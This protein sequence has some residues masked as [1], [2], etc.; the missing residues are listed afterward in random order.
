VVA[1]HLY[2]GSSVDFIADATQN[3]IASK[4][5]ATFFHA[6]RYHAPQS[7]VRSWQ[8]SLRAMAT[9]LQL[10][11][12]HDNG[13]IVEWQLPLSS[14]R[15]DIMV[16]G[17][18]ADRRAGAVIVELKQW[19]EVAE[20]AIEDCVA[21]FVGGRERDVLHPSRQVDNYQR[22]LEDTHTAF[23][24]GSIALRSCAY[25]H[26]LLYDP[27]HLLFDK[28]FGPVLR[29]CPT[30]ASDRLD[31]LVA[32]VAGG[33]G[34]GGG[35]RVM[36][37]VLEGR[38]RPH[39]RLLDH[40]AQVIRNEPTYVLLDEQQVAF[41]A[42]LTRVRTYKLSPERTVFLIKGGP[43]TGK[44]VIALNLVAALSAQGLVTH[45]ATG[46]KAFTENLR[47]VVGRRAAAQFNY[48]NSYAVMHDPLDVLVLDEAHR[49]RDTSANRFTPKGQRSDQKQ[50]EELL[51]AAQIT[52]FF[53]DDMQVVRPGE[54]GSAQLIRDAAG[55]RGIR[56]VEHELETQ[57]R[58]A[59]SDA[60]VSW[61]ENTFGL[62]RSADVLWDANDRFEF[63]VVDSAAEL[64]GLIRERDAEGASARLVA[65]FCW[66][67]SKPRP[68]GTL[69]DDVHVGAWTMPWNAKPDAGRLAP[70][71]PK[72]NYWA[73]DPSGI[74]QV[75]C[76]YTAQGFEFDYVGVII[77]RDLV[78]RP[79]TGWV[80]Q[81][82]YS[83]DSVVRR[84]R[85]EADF[86]RL[87]QHT[88]RVLLSRGLRGCYVYFQDE[89][90]RDFVLSRIE[91]SA[92]AGVA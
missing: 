11:E 12:L 92:G 8:N 47:K 87:V 73:S 64:E 45:H 85:G 66:P 14:K 86:R 80:G 55:A 24:D 57:F 5:E 70:G 26:N 60:F 10:G 13:V 42:V 23:S 58:C 82:E 37:R 52:V 28:R 29:L 21:T 16:T 15:L 3:T 63:D 79:R 7:E 36:E 89:A 32:Y 9:A 22:Y 88:Y 84:A 20:S 46:S 1:V 54:V 33:V 51:D 17:D 27:S 2:S 91:G 68:D 72:A 59:G 90:T 18:D 19:Q 25:L 34:H 50:V 44:S 81:P 61:V 40:T 78:Y 75:G 65:G 39:K 6:F 38:Y 62:R 56:V 30:F 83:H 49:I 43:G 74:D 53:I 41:N 35:V 77:G 4:L 31:D 69:V 67:W 76:V 48:F 71:I